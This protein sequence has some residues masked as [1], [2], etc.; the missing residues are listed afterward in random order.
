[1]KKIYF[2]ILALT[3][4]LLLLIGI[5]YLYSRRNQ[6]KNTTTTVPTPNINITNI[7]EQFISPTL[8]QEETV[9]LE[10]DKEFGVWTQDLYDSYPWYDK[11]PFITNNY[12]IY[13]DIYAKKFIV[14][15]YSHDEPD[16]IKQEIFANLNNIGVDY[17][18]YE[19]EWRAE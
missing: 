9:Q 18:Q 17:T 3:L 14:A 8:T 5:Y 7:Q 12:F 13:F 10:S 1:M 19:F 4:V 2:Y 16:L 6:P 15:L 11:L